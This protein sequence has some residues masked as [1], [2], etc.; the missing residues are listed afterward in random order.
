MHCSVLIVGSWI[1]AYMHTAIH[2][3]G[4]FTWIKKISKDVYSCASFSGTRVYPESHEEHTILY[5]SFTIVGPFGICCI[6][7]CHCCHHVN[8]EWLEADLSLHSYPSY[9]SS[10]EWFEKV[11]TDSISIKYCGKNSVKM[12]RH[13]GTT[14][15]SKS[16]GQGRMNQ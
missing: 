14:S 4:R 10:S 6:K 13:D 3:N 1:Q 9:G 7:A 2:G 8:P 12:M 5:P 16:S 15:C 11:N